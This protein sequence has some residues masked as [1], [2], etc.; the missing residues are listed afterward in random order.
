MSATTRPA[1]GRPP[2]L[3]VVTAVYAFP[4]GCHSLFARA[5]VGTALDDASL[6][7]DGGAARP[8]RSSDIFWRRSPR[9]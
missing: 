1:P 9:L 3:Y 2:D 8:T 5:T 7:I 6:P 4:C